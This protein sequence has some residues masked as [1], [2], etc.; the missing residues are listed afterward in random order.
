MQKDSMKLYLKNLDLISFKRRVRKFWKQDFKKMTYGDISKSINDVLMV[1]GRFAIP[2]VI[3]KIPPG[4][5]LFRIRHV[6]RDFVPCDKDC[7]APP[8]EK[9]PGG[10][11]NREGVP[12]L[13]TSLDQASVFR[14]MPIPP[15][16]IAMM[17]IYEVLEEIS[18]SSPE[19]DE[20][21]KH[22]LTK[23]EIKQ[24]HSIRSFLQ[25]LFSIDAEGSKHR[26]KVSQSLVVN[27]VDYPECTAV[28]YTTHYPAFEA[29]GHHV[30]IKG[31]NQNQVRLSSVEMISNVYFSIDNKWLEVAPLRYYDG[32]L[33]ENTRHTQIRPT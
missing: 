22:N 18:C 17:M 14:E 33:V 8:K 23:R 5:Q 13:Y 12:W 6:S 3:K 24:L 30:A 20:Q 9:V 19:F 21:N 26:Y 25:S 29:F 27:L 16:K 15:G 31:Q 4:T 2:A 32:K 1:G 28:F 7:W 11:V 10:R